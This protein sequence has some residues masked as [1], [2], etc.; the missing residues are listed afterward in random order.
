MSHIED[1][2][3]I[4]DLH[5]AALVGRDGSIDWLCLPRFDSPACFAALLGDEDAGPL[6]HRPGRRRRRAP[7]AA[8]A[9][10]PWS[11]RP[12]GTP[13]TAPSGSS[14][15]CPRAGEARR[16]RP[17]RRGRHAAPCDMR[18]EL[19]LRFDY[20]RVVPWVRHADDGLD[21]GR[22][23]G[24][25]LAATP[26]C[27]CAATTSDDGRVHRRAPGER[28]PFVLTY[29]PLLRAAAARRSTRP[30]RSADTR[31]VLDA[32]GSAEHRTTGAWR[33][34]RTRA[35]WSCSRR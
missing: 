26:R 6:A 4:G 20:G 17:H 31:R 34:R 29:A 15:S 8:T 21:R 9:A 27:R 32:T 7:A 23:T 14:T 33:G 2:A 18:S 16:R 30:R 13:P 25:G 1:Y 10:T 19:R 11:W 35:R 28:V 5:T 24:R 3:L 12:S 22:R